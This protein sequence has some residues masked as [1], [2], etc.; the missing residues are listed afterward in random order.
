MKVASHQAFTGVPSY[1]WPACAFS[2]ST[3]HSVVVFLASNLGAAETLVEETAQL[4]QIL[5][6]IKA[7]AKTLTE[8]DAVVP[9]F[10]ADCDLL[11]VLTA[12]RHGNHTPENPLFIACTPGSITRLAPS[13][14][15]SDKKELII[16]KG[17]RISL[18][19]VAQKLST[20]FGYAHESLCEQ[21]GEYALRGGILDVYPINGQMPVRVDLF[22]DTVESLRPFDPSTQKSE[23][24]I[25]SVVICAP[26]DDTSTQFDAP[27]FTHLPTQSLVIGI[28]QVF[29]DLVCEPLIK[30]LP[31]L[32]AL[33]E[34]DEVESGWEAHAVECAPAESLLIGKSQDSTQARIELL[35]QVSSLTRKDM[36]C[37]LT[38]DTQ[39]STERIEAD[40][41]SL[42]LPKF[43]PQIL[44]GRFSGGVII[45]SGSL[46]GVLSKGLVL[47]TERE[48]FG[49][50]KRPLAS[51][52]RRR[53]AIQ[54]AVGRALDF[55]EIVN[56]DALV[57][58]TQGICL[59]RGIKPFENRGR[60]E[61]YISLEFANKA[62][63]HLPLR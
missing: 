3:N 57:H 49:R 16:Q 21:P 38:G 17:D 25:N 5:K 29:S 53:T 55:G 43:K 58:A 20:N 40:V 10:E 31:S 61:D 54:A 11:G 22:G 45:K 35:K 36:V 37:L 19:D 47:L 46:T 56:G 52:P 41:K 7:T 18:R 1:A 15:E 2:E 23:G 60:I 27:F 63:L 48:L 6:G 42:D 13:A 44:S 26:R 32:L 30:N 39:G 8:S 4:L 12:I 34:T 59:F 62:Q 50:K 28:N 24:E 14:A 9:I 33:E 51:L